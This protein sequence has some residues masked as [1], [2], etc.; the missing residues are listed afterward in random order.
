MVWCGVVF[1]VDVICVKF[2]NFVFLLFLVLV[3]ALV[4]FL[5]TPVYLSYSGI[6]VKGYS[7]DVELYDV[8][9][10]SDGQ[11]SMKHILSFSGGWLSIPPS[12]SNVDFLV[13]KPGDVSIDGLGFGMEVCVRT[14]AFD[15]G[16]DLI[17][18]V[19]RKYRSSVIAYFPM[20]DVDY[21]LNT[22]NPWNHFVS[23]MFE[24]SPV[25]RVD[26]ISV[27]GKLSGHKYDALKSYFEDR[28][29]EHFNG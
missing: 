10:G 24:P 17:R 13:L 11:L 3:I 9:F 1:F 23:T 16:L 18:A 4:V 7:N 15:T 25:V 28:W 20:G 5:V 29:I 22:S 2:R 26:S 27:R 8:G 14:K 6:V 21:E 12:N 19:I